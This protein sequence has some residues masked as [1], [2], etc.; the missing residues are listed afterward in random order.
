METARAY[1]VLGLIEGASFREVMEAHRDLV[2]VWDP[3]RFQGNLRLQRRAMQELAALNEAFDTLRTHAL[4]GRAPEHASVGS[5]GQDSAQPVVPLVNDTA[6]RRSGL[7][8]ASLLDDTLPR[9][10]AKRRLPTW[11]PLAMGVLLAVVVVTWILSSDSGSEIADEPLSPT[12]SSDPARGLQKTPD[13]ANLD[14]QPDSADSTPSRA[15]EADR[16]SP[17]TLLPEAVQS[18]TENVGP[19]LRRAFQ[20]LRSKSK[21]AEDLVGLGHIDDLRYEGW[22]PLRAELHEVQVQLVAVR[23]P[24]GNEVHLIWSVNLDTQA[25]V[26]LNEAARELEERDKQSKPHLVRQM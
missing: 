9:R 19:A 14:P 8:R 6:A 23:E 5:A 4:Q 26:P 15:V 17:E 7:P 10:R 2:Q 3:K 24:E 12:G 1:E 21:A 13:L 20:L 11:L 16:G 22:K 18:R 25:V